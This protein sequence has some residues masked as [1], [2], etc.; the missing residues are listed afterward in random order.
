MINSGISKCGLLAGVIILSACD[1]G[2]DYKPPEVEVPTAYKESTEFG[3][4]RQ[5]VPKD[6]LDRGAWWSIYKDPVLD[7]LERQV[8]VSNQN[9][10]AAE[11][12]YREAKTAADETRAALFPTLTLNSNVG[13]Q[14]GPMP[15]STAANSIYGTALWTADVWGRIRRGV[16]SNEAK[17]QASSADL[18]SARLSMQSMLA[19]NYFDLRVQDELKRI[20]DKTIEID[21]KSL[22]IVQRQYGSG[23]GALADVLSEKSQLENVQAQAINVGVKRAQLEHAIAVLIGKPPSEFSLPPEKFAYEVP[24]IPSG[25]PSTLLER[26]PDVASAERAV[27]AANAQ[28]GV[29]QAARFPELTLSA[30]SGFA[31]MSLSKLLQ[32]SNSFWAVG[33]AL[34]EVVLDAG[35]REAREEQANA[36]YD[37]S[38]ANYR[39]TVL[40]AFQQVEDNLAAQRILA[41]QQKVQAAAVSHARDVEKL[42]RAQYGRGINPYS[43]VL[44]AQSAALSNEQT[45][46][47]L[48]QSRMDASVA[49]IQALGGAWDRSNL[50]LAVP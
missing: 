27:A 9:L 23:T 37:Q 28:I 46:L 30:S 22:Q 4:W 25:F 43:S 20:F 44:V 49:L 18:A 47:T 32:A 29:A 41:E 11:A 21:N 7:N 8:Q 17:A 33:P 40:A 10:K 38:V 50:R 31:S 35:G 48:H 16:E 42:A 36:A 13:R 1:V 19:T 34:A 24:D 5:A 39:Q 14:V 45:L 12:A 6:D 2:P 26:R 15:T 3:D